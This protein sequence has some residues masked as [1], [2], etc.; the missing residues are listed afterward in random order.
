MGATLEF[1]LADEAWIPCEAMDGSLCELGLRDTL[2]DIAKENGALGAKLTGGGL[3]GYMIALCAD[4]GIQEKVA[5][6]IED[7]GFEAL[8]TAIGV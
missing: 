7:A 4:T 3:G 8:R 1:N 6:A 5:G 2:V